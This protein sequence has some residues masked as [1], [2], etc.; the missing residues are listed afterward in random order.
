MSASID[1][2]FIDN[3]VVAQFAR[4]AQLRV[5]FQGIFSQKYG[6]MSRYI[7]LIAYFGN[8]PI[9]NGM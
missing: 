3:T 1:M 5:E 8:F 2:P 6:K 4:I 7:V 9:K